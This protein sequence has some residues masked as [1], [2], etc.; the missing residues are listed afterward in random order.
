MAFVVEVPVDGGG[1]LFVEASPADST[2]ELGLAS[3]RPGTVV[4]RARESL[5]QSLD[6][7]QPAIGAI[8]HRLTALAPDELNVEFGLRV[9]AETGLVVAKGV[10]EVHFTVK[11]AWQ[12]GSAS[13]QASPP[14]ATPTTPTTAPVSP[15][16]TG[17]GS[18]TGAPAPAD[19]D[20]ALPP[21]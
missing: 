15:P 21:V 11:L 2:D 20:Q 10:G 16:S 18:D 4:T 13:P 9:S 1:R 8:L 6:D 19:T 3:A 12:R 14:S 7:L 17:I 5:E